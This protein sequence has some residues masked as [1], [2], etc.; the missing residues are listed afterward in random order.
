MSLA[1]GITAF[2]ALCMLAVC[3]AV[4]KKRDVWLV[5]VFVSVAICDGGYFLLS[6]SKSLGD[7]LNSNRIAYLGSVFLPFFVLMMILRFC[8]MKRGKRLTI[9][10]VVLGVVMLGITTSPGILPIYYST[11]DI[12]FVD[13]GTKLVREYGPLHLLYYVYLLGYM[14]SMV[15]VVLYAIAKKKIN[16][17]LHTLLLLCAAFCNIAI[18]LVEQFLPRGFE[19]LSVSYILTECLL[20]AIYRSMQKQGTAWQNEKTHS[21][22][23][24]VLLTVFLLLLANFVRVVTKDTTPALYI[25]SHVLVLIIYLGI[26]VS[27]GVSVYDRI[28]NKSI[29]RYL[30]ALAALMIL[31]MLART[32]RHTVFL[33]VYPL[34]MWCWYAYYISMNL[35]PVLCLF[36]AKYIG[37]TIN[38]TSIKEAFDNLPT[39]VCF[40]N[41]EGLPVLCN[42]A[43][44]RFSF[45]VSGKDVQFITDLES[46]LADDFA[47]VGETRKDGRVFILPNGSA[48]HLEKRTFDHESGTVYTQFIAADVSDLH[49]NRMELMRENAQLRKVQTELQR[50]SAN[51]VTIT[52]EEEILNTKMRVHD[53]M[54][55]CLVA[56]QKYLDASSE[57]T[58]P[59]SVATSWQR[60]VSMLKYNNDAPDEDM[61]SQIR[62]TCEFVELAFIQTGELPKQ[63]DVAYLLTCAVR[64]CVTNAVRYAAA[65]ELYA[66]FAETAT[67]AYVT[68][69]N[70]G[71]PPER[72]IVEGGGLST[73]R[74][75]VE[76]AGGKMTVQSLPHFKL[77]VTVPKRKDGV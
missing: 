57:E 16:S 64:E 48:W 50:L 59:D 33:F 22:T 76:Q 77:T 25:I 37:K 4:D 63:E 21:Y 70:N 56:A 67:V 32:L 9:P 35:I 66:D 10:L 6:I 29:R 23:I 2:I 38:Q 51:V 49:E 24:N 42:L 18:W 62:K 75:R 55:R 8:G 17:H 61:L 43:M 54:G 26:L 74:R 15:G 5:L 39:G 40:F 34:G 11:V 31:W 20:L 44:Y 58:I 36:A 73:L 68:V 65:S 71:A 41:E 69:T 60:A 19:W 45:A 53:E 14:M 52:R 30:M 46:C 27:W 72:E 12:A 28:V 13:G 1:Y 47:P 7:A 3:V